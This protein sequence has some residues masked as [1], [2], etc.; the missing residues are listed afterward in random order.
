MR[1][2]EGHL[3]IFKLLFSGELFYN[4]EIELS[5]EKKGEKIEK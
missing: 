1:D 3:V 2:D 5:R 4:F